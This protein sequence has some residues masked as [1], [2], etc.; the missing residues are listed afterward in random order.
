MNTTRPQS[1]ATRAAGSASFGNRLR[2]AA[3]L[4]SVIFGAACAGTACAQGWQPERPVEIIVGTSAGGGQDT[5]ARFLQKLL[6]E[7][8]LLPVPTTVVNRPGAGSAVAYTSLNQQ[9][10]N[11]HQIMLLTTPLITNYITGVSP[12]SYA[13]LTPLSMLFD[14]Y[15]VATVVAGSP[16][17]SGRDLLEKLKADPA[18]VAFGIPSITGGGGLAALLVAKSVGV[19]P[20]QVK[21]V[22][23]KSGGD[24]MAALLGG[25]IDVMTSTTA[26]PVVQLKSGAVRV[27]AIASPRRVGGVLAGVPTWRELGV[28]V[29]LSNWR[30]LVGPRG[31]TPAQI[32]YWE[33][34]FA[35]VVKLE[36]FRQDVESNLWVANYRGSAEMAKFLKAEQDEVR[37]LLTEL[38]LAKR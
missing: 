33:G 11:G 22:V 17:K 20:K 8:K 26:A 2:R 5:S 14:D 24:S 23:F 18:S 13:D 4:A 10:G 28:N 31:L 9:P 1:N 36:E 12:V 38:G 35:K 34:V 25:H 6:Q 29:E 7:H 37:G 27:I 15:V 16:L 3:L 19:S 21:T 30:G 32:A